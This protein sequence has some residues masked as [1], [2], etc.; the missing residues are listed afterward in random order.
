MKIFR[1]IIIGMFIW[2]IGVSIYSL[3]FY[4]PVLEDLELQANIVL[5][6]TIVPLVWFGCHIY[7][8]KDK[9]IH[10]F[11]L[12]QTLFIIAGILDALITVPFL[13]IP[14]GGSYHSF[15]TDISFWLV[16]LEFIAT[17]MLYWFVKV[18]HRVQKTI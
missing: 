8:K 17:A 13:I 7:Y 10:G 12:G 15:F 4:V 6:T 14:N 3:S 5:F 1:A 16:A 9:T 2:V 11:L 18:Y